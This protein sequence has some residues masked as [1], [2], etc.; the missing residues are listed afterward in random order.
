[1][2]IDVDSLKEQFTPNMRSPE[3][4]ILTLNPAL[5]RIAHLKSLLIG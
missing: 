5:D 4:L 3:V 2:D 1:M